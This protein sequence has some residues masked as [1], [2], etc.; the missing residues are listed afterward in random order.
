MQRRRIRVMAVGTSRKK[1]L[2]SVGRATK[3]VKAD[4][5]IE[6]GD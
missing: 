1:E 3:V 5:A 4:C 2:W 6:I